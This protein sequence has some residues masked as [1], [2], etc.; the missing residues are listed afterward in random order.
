MGFKTAIVMYCDGE[1]AHCLRTAGTLD[2]AATVSLV[3]RLYPDWTGETTAGRCL[4][5]GIHPSDGTIYAGSFPA[6][7]VLC[8]RAVAVDRPAELADEYLRLGAGRSGSVGD[9]AEGIYGAAPQPNHRRAT[10]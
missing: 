3:E 2:E 6:A 1:P 8:D 10:R 5:E 7:D 4:S 9:P